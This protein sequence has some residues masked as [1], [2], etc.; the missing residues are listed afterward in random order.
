MIWFVGPIARLAER[1]ISDRA[2][3]P[4]P[5]RVRAKYLAPVFLKTPALALDQVGMELGHLGKCVVR[6]LDAAP[7]AVV[8]GVAADLD[9]VEAMDDDVDRLHADILNYMAILAREELQISETK[10]MEDQIEIANNLEA[11]GDLIET[12]LVAQG[13]QLITEKI[14]LSADT[15]SAMEPLYDAVA[16]SLDDVLKALEAEDADLGREVVARKG[17][18]RELA[19]AATDELAGEL[20]ASEGEG[21]SEFRIKSDIVNQIQRLFYHVRRIAKTMAGK[22][23]PPLEV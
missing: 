21:V 1:L 18:I 11:I 5:Q 15:K 20:L 6:M 19:G 4:E 9:S 2:P 23:K 22:E 3:E 8:G 14:S 17:K 7:E 10:R 13:R 16:G 12:N